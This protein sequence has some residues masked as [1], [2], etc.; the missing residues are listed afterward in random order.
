MVQQLS[1]PVSRTTGPDDDAAF[2][3]P[4]LVR[5]PPP[6]GSAFTDEELERL[7]TENPGWRFE[8]DCNG[9]LVI[10][11]GSGGVTSD[12][13]AEVNGQIGNWRVAGGGGRIRTSSGGY[14]LGGQ[15][16]TPPE[17][18]PDTSWLS[19]QQVSHLTPKQRP[20]RGYWTVCPAFIIEIR[21]HGDSLASQ[22]A[23]M[24]IW[25]TLGVQLGWLI[26]PLEQSVWIYRPDQPPEQLQRPTSLSGEQV[27]QGLRVD[28]AE[29]WAFA[30]EAAAL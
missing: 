18:E 22:Q 14:W 3:L 13:E 26:D 29:V 17:M 12:I 23:K 27:L 30:A 24:D 25:M 11:M 4:A 2:S 9:A 10:N 21:S 8:V 28:M 20:S 1:Q 7:D 19:D 15:P 16:R 6:A 5:V